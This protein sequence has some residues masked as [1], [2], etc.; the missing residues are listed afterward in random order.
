MHHMELL[1]TPAAHRAMRR[2]HAL[3]HTLQA[4]AFLAPF[5]VFFVC[6]LMLPVLWLFWLTFHSEG[7]LAPQ[8][9]VGWENWHKTFA[10]KLVVKTIFNTVEYSLMAIP[11]VFVLAMCLAL[12]LKA[13]GRGRTFF[14]TLLYIPT[15]QP[16]LIIAL[17]WTFMLHPDFGVLNVISRAVL[18]H[19]I[20]FLGQPSNALPTIAMIEVWRGLGFWTVLFLSGLMAMPVELFHAAELDGAGPVRRFFR[21]TLPLMKPTFFFAIIFA[22]IANLQ[23]FDSV[24]AL[25]DGGPANSTAT[26]TW[27]I[28][29]SLFDFGETGFGSTL[30]FV[31]VAVVLLL[32]AVQTLLLRGRG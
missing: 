30:S 17:I 18:G 20:N 8:V 22:T 13:I 23:L 32:T 2:R 28:Y 31:L 21:L 6:F 1:H 27:Y 5:L 24:F 15:L 11:A 26:V 3:R 4:Y 19:P 7:I 12:A 14:R 9:F 16:S 10:N 29:R 25:T